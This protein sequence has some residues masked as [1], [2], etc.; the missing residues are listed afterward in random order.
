[1]RAFEILDKDHCGFISKGL[2]KQLLDELYMNYSD[3]QKAGIPKAAVKNILVTILD[4][5][6]DG[7]ISLDD[8]L[9]FLDVTRLKLSAESKQTFL[10]VC[11]PSVASSKVVQQARVIVMNKYFDVVID[12]VGI[13]LIF[14]MLLIDRNNIYQP[15]LT[16]YILTGL[17]TFVYLLDVILKLC[18]RGY[19]NYFRYLRNKIDFIITVIMLWAFLSNLWYQSSQ[20]NGFFGVTIFIQIVRIT[21]MTRIILFPRHSA[22]FVRSG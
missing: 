10:E 17:S 5:D 14:A 7:K 19:N 21:Q 13:T 18:L 15:T 8:F 11:W 9:F 2:A 3:F 12:L 20:R 16:S 1:M 4:V 6:N 22:K